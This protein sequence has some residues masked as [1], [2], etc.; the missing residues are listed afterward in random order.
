MSPSSIVPHGQS[1]FLLV[2]EWTWQCCESG[3][4]GGHAYNLWLKGHCLV[5]VTVVLVQSGDT[6]WNMCLVA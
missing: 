6:A 2:M 3:L 5:T 1:E 4:L